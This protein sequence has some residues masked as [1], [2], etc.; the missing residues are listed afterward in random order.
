MA[1]RMLDDVEEGVPLN[2][3][4]A[5]HPHFPAMVVQMVAVGEETGELDALLD[6]VADYYDTETNYTIKNLATL[7][8]PL[9]LLVMGCVVGLIALAIFMPMWDMMNVMRG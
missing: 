2:I 7:I 6:K 4:M 1:G 8:E 5:K 3:A 9:L